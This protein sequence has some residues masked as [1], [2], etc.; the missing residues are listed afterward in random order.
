MKLHWLATLGLTLALPACPSSESGDG[1]TGTGSSS[2]DPVTTDMSVTIST[3]QTSMS[4]TDAT[5]TSV[6]TDPT[7]TTDE[8]TTTDPDTS[9]TT[10]PETTTDAT[11]GTTDPTTE[12]GSTGPD[13]SSSTGDGVV[14]YPPCDF[15]GDPAGECAGKG[16]SCALIPAMNPNDP[17]RHWCAIPCEMGD[18]SG[19]PEPSS[20]DATVECSGL[21]GAP[22]A[23]SC[24]DGETCPDGMVCFD[25]MINNVMR[26]VWED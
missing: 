8:P 7:T 16:E 13:E 3:T 21:P 17:D 4:A 6:T 23:L 24:A 22:C 18:P 14:T 9:A 10:A 12:T 5:M 26:C 1:G 11:D 19:C 25:A 15:D 20:G 2:G